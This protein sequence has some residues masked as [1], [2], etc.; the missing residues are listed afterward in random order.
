[1]IGAK[2]VVIII[3]TDWTEGLDRDELQNTSGDTEWAAR[4]L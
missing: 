3:P 2:V 1:M 4:T